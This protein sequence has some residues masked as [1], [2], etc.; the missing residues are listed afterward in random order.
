[1]SRTP[2]DHRITL[3]QAMFF[4]VTALGRQSAGACER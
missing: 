3:N 1:M 2:G 4:D